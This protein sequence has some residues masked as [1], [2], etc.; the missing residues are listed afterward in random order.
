LNRQT[1][2]QQPAFSVKDDIAMV[3]FNDPSE[4]INALENDSDN[5]SPNGKY[6][7][8]VTTRGL[9]A[10]DQVRSVIEVF[11]VDEIKGFLSSPSNPKPAPRIVASVTA[12]S[13]GQ[14]TIPYASIIHDLR[15]ADD[16]QY[17]YF[18]GQNERGAYQLYQARID[19]RGSRI[20]TPATD[21]V[22]RFDVAGDTIAYTAARIDAPLPTP[23]MPINRDAFDA[24]GYRSF[25]ILFPGR[26][27]SFEVKTFVMFT[28][29]VGQHPSLPRRVPG[30]SVPDNSLFQYL[31]PFRISPDGRWLVSVEPVVGTIPKFW[32]SFD[33]TPLFEHRR[34]R[35]E[36]PDLARPDNVLRSRRYTLTDLKTGTAT[37]LVDAPSAEFLGYV[38]EANRAVW[39]D[40]GTRVLVTNLYFPP[41]TSNAGT[42]VLHRKPCAVASI[43]I[44]SLHR[45]C[46]YFD[47][48]AT[49]WNTEH[50]ADVSFGRNRNETMV[51]M[52]RETGER[53]IVAFHLIGETWSFDSE[54]SRS[55]AATRRKQAAGYG[56]VRVYVKQDLNERSTLWAS[57]VLT[58]VSRLL[59]DPN[60]QL[61]DVAFGQARV[62]RW[63]DSSGRDWIGGLVKPVG[64]VPGQR[65]PLVIQMYIF[66]EHAFLTD[67]TDPSAFVA[68]HLAS[69]GFVVLQVRKQPNVLSDQDAQTSLAGYKSAIQQLSDDGLIDSK[70]VGVVGFSWTCWYVINALVKAPKL[71]AAA[72]IAD[73]LDNS[74]M[75]YM[76]GTPSQPNFEA[77]STQ[78][79]GGSPFGAGLERWVREA[80]AFHLDQVQA[81]VRIEAMGPD[82]ILQ[83]W[84]LYAALYL[85]HKPV[86]LIY[87]PDGTHIHQMP[88]ERLESQQG[89]IDWMRFW[90]QGYEDPDPTKR[91]QYQRWRRL[92][93]NLPATHS[94]AQTPQRR[95]DPAS[96][97]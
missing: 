46:L 62:Y 76:F 56:N 59:W 3:R 24:T 88:L 6:I 50:V 43:D 10:S 64:Y 27:R 11:D 19:G 74:Y 69:V 2:A 92:K 22:D 73:G 15:W 57:N 44:R 12:V 38:E 47:G 4:D 78:I 52:K 85:Q 80:P 75:Q 51:T 54:N 34:L 83:E 66:R 1:P 86:D 13:Q 23:G 96:A 87:F 21:D 97:P 60:P 45:R 84:E 89:N 39:S 95:E 42:A 8:V 33:P 18:R 17:I 32:E 25:E 58:T 68:R 93:G 55:V 61:N 37:T 30:Y 29:R 48:A 71:F 35:V 79:R 81:P 36:D 67:G 9:L 41:D 91:A 90:L 31:F 70:R 14:Q 63:K 7:A 28:L 77:Q 5:Y 72:T 20:L 94:N 65:Y 82:S 53:D 49:P 16:S 26:V 40:D